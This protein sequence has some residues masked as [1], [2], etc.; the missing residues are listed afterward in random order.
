MWYI[1]KATSICYSR[2]MVDSP[3]LPL[4]QKHTAPIWAAMLA[5]GLSL[6]ALPRW[7]DRSATA[8]KPL[9][10]AT[11]QA[12]GM[13]IYPHCPPLPPPSGNTIGVSS[14]QELWNAVNN[15]SPGDTILIADGT[16]NLAAHGYF[17]WIDTPGVNLRSAS[18]NRE[19]VILDE[20]YLGSETVTVAASNVTIADLTIQR[21]RTHPIHVV[22]TDGGDTLNTL[23]YNVH[24][25][26][27]G[28]QA[29]KINPHGDKVYFP[30]NGEIACSH[31][32][33]T[34]AGRPRIWEFNR[35]CYTGGVDAHWAWGWSIHD[36]HIEGF[37][38]DQGLSEHAIHLWTGS[39]ETLV[40]RNTL[41][42]NARGVGFG[43]LQSGSGRTYSD[44]PC[45]GVI[46]YVDHYGGL[47]RN[48]FIQASRS[49]LFASQAGFDC[50]ICLAQACDAKVLHNSVVSTSAPFSSIEW[51]FANTSA[52]VTNNLLSHNL[53][54]RDGATATL[55]GNLEN[56][57]QTL[58]M[59]AAGGDLHL[60][61]GAGA[62]IDQG[63]QVTAGLCE[64]D[65]DGDPRPLGAARDIGADEYGTPLPEPVSDLQVDSAI[66]SQDTITATLTWTA[67]VSAVLIELRYSDHP[68]TD[69]DW[70]DR[71][72]ITGDLPGSSQ[73][74]TAAL[75]YA[76]G[77]VYF[78]LKWQA[79]SE[80]WSPV[81]NN[82]FWP[83]RKVRLPLIAR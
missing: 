30:D 39:R 36:N 41:V 78:A 17:L 21:T 79:A 72:L 4:S 44:D 71:P 65:I 81:S 3:L 9:P 70:D 19:A 29:I 74:H 27:P 66:S 14:E 34:D 57:P 7:E 59:D 43:L 2:T 35:S 18:G 5:V 77:T 76:G 67:P 11:S 62:A 28:Q 31:I 37:W 23:I 54:E 68:I 64:E 63:A 1:S 33:L 75:G 26:D 22:S 51:R 15:A 82:A 55:A 53:R 69:N 24:L 80:L 25:I 45:P 56:A 8:S 46:G 20:N 6:L 12:S 73:S 58:F 32:E 60:V 83:L 13:Q 38:C 10:M 50:G 16:Y 40:E 48:N 61:D 47:I 52:E 42:D 49:E